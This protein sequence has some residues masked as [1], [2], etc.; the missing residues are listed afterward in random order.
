MYPYW[1]ARSLLLSFSSWIFSVVVFFFT[2]HVLG[3]TGVIAVISQRGLAQGEWL[4]TFG[5]AFFSAFL[6]LTVRSGVKQEVEDSQ[7]MYRL[8]ILSA[9]LGW[10][11]LSLNRSMNGGSLVAISLAFC[12]SLLVPVGV[13]IRSVNRL[14]KVQ[15]R[16]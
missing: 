8:F 7:Y 14:S 3:N 2:E 10:M 6:M 15:E 12:S 5:P 1:F 16:S 13:L 4:L 9:M 11:F